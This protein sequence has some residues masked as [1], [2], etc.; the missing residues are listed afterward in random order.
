MPNLKDLSGAKFGHSTI[1]RRVGSSPSGYV[2]WLCRCDCGAEFE[3]S[4][5]NIR[6]GFEFS[7]GCAPRLSYNFIDLAGKRVGRLTVIDRAGM[8]RSHATWRCLCDC[9]KELVVRGQSLRDGISRSC[10]CYKRDSAAARNRANRGS[11][12]P[13]WRGGRRINKHGYVLVYVDNK[14]G[15]GKGNYELEHRVKMAKKIGRPLHAHENVHHKN[16][17][18]SDNRLSNLEL[19][20]TMQ[21]TGK[22]VCDLVAYAEEILKLY[23]NENKRRA[24][25]APDARR[26]TEIH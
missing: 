4:S 3:R 12:S 7:C 17:D 8:D 6:K 10:G 26:H 14:G 5:N 15:D 2:V 1:L 23:K 19:W 11:K 24:P 13:M 21:P 16:G 22:R 20:S 25:T 9:G 18:R